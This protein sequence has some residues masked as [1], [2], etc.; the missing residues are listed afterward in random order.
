MNEE[1]D[2]TQ[3]LLV[4]DDD[5][6]FRELMKTILTNEGFSVD[7]APNG[8]EGIHKARNRSYDLILL[9]LRMPGIDGI[10]TLKIL[11]P[12]CP[13]TDFIVITGYGDVAIAVELIK[14]GAREYFTK[15]IEPAEFI[16]R[17]K[18]SLRAHAAELRIKELQSDFSSRLLHDL[19]GPVVML[20]SALEFLR[21]EKAGPV[22]S[23]QRLILDQ[24]STNAIRMDAL[25][26]DMIDLSLFESGR[27]TID[28]LPVNLDVVLPA[29]R[30]RLL[31]LASAR[32]IALQLQMSDNIPTIELDLEKIEQVFNNLIDNAIKY[33]KDGGAINIVLSVGRQ[34]FNDKLGE[35][36]NIAIS[37]TGVGIPKDELPFVFDKYKDMLTGKT[38]I[39]KTTGLGLAICRSIVEAHNG[40]MTADSE[41]N[42]G[43]TINVHLPTN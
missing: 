34:T 17:I 14:L 41:V 33:S 1:T 3:R 24:M 21:N 43:T 15:P 7:T 27:V 22:T 26:N 12:E 23:E 40:I 38:S 25:L 10:E 2:R 42:K 9:D 36:V 35:S 16:Q 18:T 30:D 11:K 31:P 37:D 6:S 5:D 32:N 13:A 39:K 19:R 8:E 4:V 29:I 28:K 20:S